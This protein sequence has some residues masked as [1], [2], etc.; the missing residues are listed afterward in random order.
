MPLVLSV[1]LIVMVVIALV[2]IAGL[3]IE[4]DEDRVETPD[5]EDRSDLSV[6][7]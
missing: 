5:S 2:A 3:L 1:A 7:S 4:R 6:A